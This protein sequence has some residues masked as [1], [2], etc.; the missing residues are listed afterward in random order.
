MYR[1]CRVHSVLRITLISRFFLLIPFHAGLSLQVFQSEILLPS[2]YTTIQ[3]WLRMSSGTVALGRAPTRLGN[4]GS[5]ILVNKGRDTIN[6][7]IDISHP[8]HTHEHIFRRSSAVERQS[9]TSIFFFSIVNYRDA[10]ACSS[11]IS[12]PYLIHKRMN[13]N[14]EWNTT[15]A[16]LAHSPHT[17]EPHQR[18]YPHLTKRRRTPSPMRISDS[19]MNERRTTIFTQNMTS[20]TPLPSLLVVLVWNTVQV[21]ILLLKGRRRNE[22]SDQ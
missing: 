19:S 22:P 3:L 11:F 7:F 1:I 5:R 2:P 15:H 14:R 18:K 9:R 20:I 21:S 10:P 13:E 6:N 8:L 16:M 12:S 4:R 17:P